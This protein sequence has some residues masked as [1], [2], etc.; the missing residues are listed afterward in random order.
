MQICTL[1]ILSLAEKHARSLAL[2]RS[3]M[4]HVHDVALPRMSFRVMQGGCRSLALVPSGLASK[5][6][7]PC[8]SSL[9]IQH[10]TRG[11]LT[12]EFIWKKY[13]LEKE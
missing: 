10:T 12:D 1:K 8:C 4:Q 5:D 9:I 11:L 2:T 3:C 6:Q 7:S 13:A